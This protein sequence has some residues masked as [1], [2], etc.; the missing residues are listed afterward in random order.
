MDPNRDSSPDPMREKV[1]LA[2]IELAKGIKIVNF[3]PPG[4][5]AL[6]QAIGK[7]VD[8]IETIPPPEDGIE[9]DVTKSALLFRETPFPTGNK[10]IADLNRELYHRRASKLILLNGQK[11]E[12]MIAFLGVL[13]RDIQ[14]LHEQGGLE[15][16][17]LR[18]KVTRIWVNRVDYEG[19][20]EMLK[21]EEEEPAPSAEDTEGVSADDQSLGLEDRLP[22]DPE[23]ED[24]LRRLEKETEAAAYRD[25]V[26]SLTRAL[27]QEQGDRR[28][29]YSGQA[30]AIY[31]VHAERPPKGNP[32]IAEFARMGIRELVS[33]DLVAHYI[34]RIKEQG[35]RN[36]TEAEAVLVAFGERAVKHLLSAL[37]EE[38]DLLARKSIVD[39]LVRIGSPA[40]PA[41]LDNLNDARWYFVRNMVTILGS[42]GDP[43]LAPHIVRSLS[44]PDLRVKK[45]AIRGL[46]RLAHP[47]AVQ[48]LAELCFFPEESIALMATAA[49]SRKKEEEAV[50][51]LARRAIQKKILFPN[52]RLAHEAIESLRAIDT[53]AA[54]SAL[55]EI[56]STRAIWL[57]ANVREMKQHALRSISRMS[58]DRAK[59]VVLRERNSPAGYLRAEAERVIKKKGW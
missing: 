30:L 56:L 18:E 28:I 13:N 35:G 31:V 36:R 3:Y 29:E 47:S 32:E 40:V 57:T 4:H 43:D 20:T 48:A 44:H 41:I 10:A 27:L 26:I 50:H 15:K 42:L 33:D 46:S 59:S 5:P 14:D 45:E 38:G 49:L 53:D 17:L 6:T 16:V 52:Y 37:S 9:I 25:L 7:I 51:T 24:L 55:E 12:E 2:A 8:A 21:R 11:P 58:G 22:Q 39:I 23:V 19:L 54:L 1:V 34:R